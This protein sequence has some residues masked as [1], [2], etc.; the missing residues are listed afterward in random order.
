IGAALAH[1]SPQKRRVY[2]CEGTYPEDLVLGA[3]HGGVS[4]F[5]AVHC[6]WSAADGVKPVVG[7]SA[8]PLKVDGVATEVAFFDLAFH[9]ADATDGGSSIA[10]FINGS[11]AALTRVALVAGNGDNGAD[12]ALTAFTFPTQGELDGN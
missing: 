10:G 8:L 6:D 3:A 9:A 1:L 11:Q 12:G 2:V 5:G 7:A 4:L